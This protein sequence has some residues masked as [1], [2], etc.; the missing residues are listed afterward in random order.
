MKMIDEQETIINLIY[1]II[2]NISIV[3]LVYKKNY[4]N[5]K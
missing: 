3:E 4:V 2:Y 5:N 1:K